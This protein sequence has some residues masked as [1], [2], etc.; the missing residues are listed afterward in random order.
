M[1]KNVLSG[2]N[3]LAHTVF[4]NSF[5]IPLPFFFLSFLSFLSSLGGENPT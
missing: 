2:S 1:E 3:L 4:F 5:P